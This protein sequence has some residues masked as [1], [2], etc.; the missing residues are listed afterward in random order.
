MLV[1]FLLDLGNKKIDTAYTPNAILDNGRTGRKCNEIDCSQHINTSDNV[2]KQC[3]PLA[4]LFFNV[5]G[6]TPGIEL[7]QHLLL[8]TSNPQ[9]HQQLSSSK[10]ILHSVSTLVVSIGLLFASMN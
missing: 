4:N 7:E 9:N 1:H 2:A 6:E 5:V 3:Q 10:A 8:P